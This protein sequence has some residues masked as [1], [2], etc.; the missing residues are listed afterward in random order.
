MNRQQIQ[1]ENANAAAFLAAY[2]RIR[3]RDN[4]PI[5]IDIED[6]VEESGL[7]DSLGWEAFEWLVAHNLGYEPSLATF[8]ALP[9]GSSP[10]WTREKMV[11]ALL[12][13]LHVMPR[14]VPHVHKGRPAVYTRHGKVVLYLEAEDEALEWDA[15][16]LRSAELALEVGLPVS[17]PD[18]LVPQVQ[19]LLDQGLELHTP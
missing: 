12:D 1:T 13:G 15:S 19:H 2:E 7:D 8:E 6:I 3:A 11:D 14:H 17:L 18:D 5:G 4:P 16:Y 10:T 9:A